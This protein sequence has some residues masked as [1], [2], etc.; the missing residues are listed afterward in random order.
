LRRLGIAGPALAAAL[1]AGGALQAQT[2]AVT[3]GEHRGFTRIVLQSRTGFA[4]GIAEVGADLRVTVAGRS[5]QLDP[6]GLFRRIPRTRLAAAR[7][8]DETLVLTR[9]CAC[10]ARIF[11]DRPGVV[12]IDLADGPPLASMAA[13][14]DPPVTPPP[15]ADPARDAGRALAR[16]FGEGRTDTPPT[17]PPD[18]LLPDLSAHL[19]A[20]L[21][22]G[23]L[24]AVGPGPGP[25]AIGPEARP[26]ALPELPPNLRLR[27]ADGPVP[28]P[29][30]AAD[31]PAAACPGPGTFGFLD[32]PAAEPFFERLSALRG[33]LYGEFDQPDPGAAL[34][35]VRHYLAYGLGTEARQ[36]IDSHGFAI[37]G[38]DLL[39]GLADLLDDLASNRR[40]R[41]SSHIGCPAPLGLFAQLARAPADRPAEAGADLAAGFLALPGPLR[42][43]LGPMLVRRLLDAGEAEWARIVID[44]LARLPSGAG[45]SEVLLA[46]EL[47]R[48]RGDLAAAADR[49]ARADQNDPRALALRLQLALDRQEIASIDDLADAMVQAEA[50]RH[51]E[52]GR[53]LA[54]LV[55]RH[56]AAA[57]R[58]AEGLAVLDRLVAW[59]AAAPGARA[60]IAA[61]RSLL[62]SAAA[63]LPDRALLDLVLARA[64]WRTELTEPEVRAALADRF[65]ALGLARIAAELASPAVPAAPLV[66]GRADDPPPADAGGPTAPGPGPDD[67]PGAAAAGAPREDLE[68]TAPDRATQA[69]GRVPAP[70]PPGLPPAAAAA[71]P[72]GT[73]APAPRSGV[74]GPAA[75]RAEPDATGS[76]TSAEPSA[77]AAAAWPAAPAAPAES[78]AT[79]ETEMT[80]AARAL[81]ESEALRAQLRELGLMRR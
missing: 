24:G 68:V 37:E 81:A 75:G 29:E 49:I 11:E 61:L 54:S 64:D 60:E 73:L 48:A 69:A 80:A 9:P 23:L 70:R 13:A 14:A 28:G 40:V 52:T 31:A 39:G 18:R 4:Y 22:R 21:S 79:A 7:I 35:L 26:A 16:R 65:R 8:E 44:S 27:G 47:D 6:E 10:P 45:G 55:I 66:D 2:V 15:A 20:A 51:D 38:R 71:D 50:E 43:A 1:W 12:V 33:R 36:I 59:S 34:E 67:R 72:G 17:L 41:L 25:A 63:G 76:G 77:A 19:A 5:L 42:A 78:P 3:A 56:H 32:G 57:G 62:W 58:P 46:A 30:P 53:H 74:A